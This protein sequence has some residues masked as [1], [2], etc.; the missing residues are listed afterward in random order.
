MNYMRKLWL[1]FAQAATLILAAYFVINTLRPDLLNHFNSGNVITTIKQARED[2]GSSHNPFSYSDA[3]QKAMPAVVNIFT[4]QAVDTK[5]HP[6]ANDPLFRFFF[7]DQGE[8]QNQPSTNL[9]SGVIV[10]DSGYILTNSHVVDSA[11]TI[12]VALADKRRVSARVIGTDPDTDLAVLKINLP[13]LPA[14]TFGSSEKAR[15]GDIVLA[16]G[17]PF[18]VGQTV[19][20]GIVSALGRSQLGINTFENFIQTDAAI[21]PGNSGGA[22]IDSSGNLIGINTAIYS[23]TP[24]GASLG[25]GFAIP[26]H[27]AK[28]IMEQIIQHGSVAR[29]WIGVAVQDMTKELAE[30]LKVK[31]VRGALITEVLRG[32]PADRSG[33]KPGDL[34]IAVDDQPITDTSNMLNLIAA[35]EPGRVANL[36]II[37]G[38]KEIELK[39]NIGKRPKQKQNTSE[40]VA[41]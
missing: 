41:P 19:T 32:M 34:L 4:S 38:G 5:R 13:N 7:G 36:K 35:L 17:N 16:I 22:L 6:M 15:V 1:L 18:G 8:S 33:I 12:E 29:G 24:G 39:V 3:A 31:E 21:N 26:A 40:E 10:T 23:R 14:I 2:S 30:S 25:I 27:T 20:M 37:R 28:S 9:G 11:T